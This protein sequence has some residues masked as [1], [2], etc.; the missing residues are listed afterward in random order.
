MA[1]TTTTEAGRVVAANAHARRQQAAAD[2]RRAADDLFPADTTTP[3][4]G[5]APL[6]A[7]PDPPAAKAP[8]KPSAT[9]TIHAL[10]DDFPFDVSFV[11]TADQLAATVDR[12]RAIGA[13]PPTPAAR[14]AVEA[15]KARSAPICEFHGA[16][17]ESSKA[18]GTWYCPSKMG[19]GSYCK[20]KG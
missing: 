5:K 15:E 13:V 4:V 7:V 16:M 20:S 9:F 18:P 8:P 14:A 10:I 19:D 3:L 11:G 17:K 12:L 1:T 6:E 2:A